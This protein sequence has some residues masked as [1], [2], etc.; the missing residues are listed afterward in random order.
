VN[1][2]FKIILIILGIAYLISPVDIIPDFLVPFLGFVDDGLVTAILYYLIRYGTLP[3][4]FL[5]KQK[6]FQNSSEQ[7]FNHSSNTKT[8]NSGA[9][10]NKKDSEPGPPK[11]PH[12]ILGV[13]PGASKDEIIAAYKKAV[14]KYHPDKVSHLGNEFSDLA[15]K[16]FLEIR[17][18]YEAL[19]K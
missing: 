6:S 1:L 12:E 14:K 16:K 4:F 10:E 8:Q 2:Y 5:K 13:P 7:K 15:N 11:T 3:A 17:N 19:I 18:A 9:K